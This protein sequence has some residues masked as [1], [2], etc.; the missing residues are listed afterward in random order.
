LKAIL[1]NLLLSF[2]TAGFF[3]SVNAQILNVQ[4]EIQDYDQWCWAA[5]SQCILAYYGFPEQQCTIAEYARET[6]TFNNFGAVNCCTDATQGCNYW[7]YN[8]G[9]TGSIQDLLVH[10]GNIQNTGIASALTPS[11]ITTELQNNRLFVIRWGWSTGG[12]HF[13]VGYGINGNNLYYMNP[14]FGEGLKI[15]TIAYVDSGVGGTGTS[16]ATHIWTH[17]NEITSNVSGIAG[18]SS[19]HPCLLYP[20]P[21]Q[22]IVTIKG[23]EENKSYHLEIINLSGQKILSKE[24]QSDNY[25]NTALEIK[26]LEKG[27]YLT[28][29]TSING[30]QL[31]VQKLILY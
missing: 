7:D 4:S 11:E 25:G 17:T 16:T 12:G 15:S 5:S 30:S 24:I 6:A 14:W 28:K 3:V 10:F 22:D 26:N 9:Y 18:L 20:N 21:T 27:T 29:L 2:L 1:K 23:L 19:S 8:Y 13:L 31:P